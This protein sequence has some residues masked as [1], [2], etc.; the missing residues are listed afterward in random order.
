MFALTIALRDIEQ[1]EPLLKWL[2]SKRSIPE[3]VA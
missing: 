1:W 2:K 3:S